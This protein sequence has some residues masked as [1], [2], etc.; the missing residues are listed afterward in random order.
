MSRFCT[1]L[2][3]GQPCGYRARPGRAFCYGHDPRSYEYQPC[4]YFNRRGQQCRN[5]ALRGQ[6][7]CHAHSPRY[8]RL[9]LGAL[10]VNPRTRRQKERVKWLLISNM[11]PFRRRPS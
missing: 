1:A 11:P 2:H 7:H 8:C 6:D 5:L 10:P 9:E 4:Q 3:E